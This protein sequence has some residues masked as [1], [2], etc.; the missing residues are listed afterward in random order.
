ME[1]E[2][3]DITFAWVHRLTKE[4]AYEF[5]REKAK[6]SRE[7]SMMDKK[8]EEV[9]KDDSVKET[10]AQKRIREA[11]DA[12]RGIPLPETGNV[13]LEN[14]FNFQLFQSELCRWAEAHTKRGL[15]IE[16]PRLTP[17]RTVASRAKRKTED[18]EFEDCEDGL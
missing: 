16:F 13:V 18:N 1:E 12:V 7:R 5:F 2:G 9:K 3:D 14:A 17:I 11:R 6:A 8:K 10:Q 15:L 4:S